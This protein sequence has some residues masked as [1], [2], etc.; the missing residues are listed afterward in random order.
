MIPP[1]GHI[2]I[3]HEVLMQQL[4]KMSSTQINIIIENDGGPIFS[5]PCFTVW[6]VVQGFHSRVSHLGEQL[7]SVGLFPV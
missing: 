1:T 5:I 4:D 3:L 2:R 6:R 7:D